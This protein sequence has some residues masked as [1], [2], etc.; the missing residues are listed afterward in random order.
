MARPRLKPAR[1]QCA[2]ETAEARSML[3]SAGYIGRLKGQL[4]VRTRCRSYSGGIWL[5]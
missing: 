4:T 2:Y 5:V 1:V 3:G